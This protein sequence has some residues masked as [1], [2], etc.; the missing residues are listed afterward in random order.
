MTQH[1]MLQ[2]GRRL[3]RITIDLTDLTTTTAEDALD[4]QVRQHYTDETQATVY[5]KTWQGVMVDYLSTLL[6]D[7]G[8]AFM[9]GKAGDVAKACVSV[10]RAAR[11]HHRAHHE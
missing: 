2:T 10:E 1:S 3:A 11:A 7:V 6:T 5:A 8:A 9:Y 4:V